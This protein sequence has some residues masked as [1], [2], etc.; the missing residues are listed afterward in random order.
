MLVSSIAIKEYVV[1]INEHKIINISINN[2]T[3]QLL[4]CFGCITMTQRKHHV[5]KQP[6][7]SDK[8]HF[9]TIIRHEPDLVIP[10]GQI[11]G[12]EIL[13]LK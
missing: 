9:L 6:V 8:C 10:T 5:F 2:C 7:S 4:E 13:G 1:E 12:T 3:N 11:N